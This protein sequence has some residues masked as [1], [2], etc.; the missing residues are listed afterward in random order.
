MTI[1]SMIVT[2]DNIETDARWVTGPRAEGGAG[3]QHSSSRVPQRETLSTHTL[4]GVD[5]PESS[6]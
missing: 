2:R 1:D 5:S 4:H 3:L 6:S